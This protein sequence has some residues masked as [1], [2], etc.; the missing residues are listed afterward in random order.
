VHQWQ[1]KPSEATT[2]KSQKSKVLETLKRSD[3][4][5]IL[6]IRAFVAKNQAERKKGKSQ[7]SKVKSQ[8]FWKP[9]AKRPT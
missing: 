4:H 5:N 7:K 2:S 8:K 1:N 9:Q 6:K 3:Q